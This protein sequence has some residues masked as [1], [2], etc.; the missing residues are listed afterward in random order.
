M[1]GLSHSSRD[2]FFFIRVRKVNFSDYIDLKIFLTLLLIGSG[3][4]GYKVAL[5]E[6]GSYFCFVLQH[7]RPVSETCNL[8]L[9][10]LCGLCF[11]PVEAFRIFELQ[12]FHLSACRSSMVHFCPKTHVFYLLQYVYYI[13]F[14]VVFSVFF[15]FS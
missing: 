6:L 8:I 7:S 12:T 14:K 4:L 11:F 5:S 15:K 9:I 1:S 2:K 3:I 13:N 10:P